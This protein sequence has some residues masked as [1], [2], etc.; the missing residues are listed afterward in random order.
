MPLTPEQ[1]AIVRSDFAKIAGGADANIAPDQLSALLAAQL[2]REPTAE[3]VNATLTALELDGNDVSLTA[4]LKYL[5]PPAPSEPEPD[6][7]N[8]PPA[9]DFGDRPHPPAPDYADLANWVAHP[10]NESVANVIV[11]DGEAPTPME[12]RPADCF[13]VIGTTYNP[14]KGIQSWNATVPY[15]PVLEEWTSIES[16]T[17]SALNQRC[18]IFSPQYRQSCLAPFMGTGSSAAGLQASA[19]EQLRQS[20]QM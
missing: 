17:S 8:P 19:P 16:M 12:E 9:F 3:E 10:D 7:S 20:C 6:F 5:E 14:G 13:F 1:A 2:C 15:D 18:R 4:W 11:P